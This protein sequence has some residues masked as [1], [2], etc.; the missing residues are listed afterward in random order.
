MELDADLDPDPLYDIRYV[1][2]KHWLTVASF[3]SF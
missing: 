3:F 2:P 1:D